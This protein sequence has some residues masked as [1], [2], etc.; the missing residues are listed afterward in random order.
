MTG[1]RLKTQIVTNHF[2]MSSNQKRHQIQVENIQTF[3]NKTK[4]VES[5]I[6][7]VVSLLPST[8]DSVS[9]GSTNP[10]SPV[11][12]MPTNEQ[13]QPNLTPLFIAGLQSSED[14]L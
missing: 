2:S 12:E 1:N 4:R 7:D 11:Q 10:V 8:S 9:D 5:G 14:P 13:E 3:I 6:Q